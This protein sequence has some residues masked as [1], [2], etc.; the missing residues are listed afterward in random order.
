MKSQQDFYKNESDASVKQVVIISDA[1][2]YEVASELMQELA[3]HK[4]IATLDAYQAMLPTETKFCKP[5]LL[6]HRSLELQGTD[7]AV[8][9]TVLTTTEQR[10]QHL[11]RYRDG[12]Y[13]VKYDKIM[14]GTPDGKLKWIPTET[15]LDILQ[16]AYGLKAMIEKGMIYFGTKY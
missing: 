14:N 2:R 15:A 6:P 16:N 10:T 8:D 9:G 1:L 3:K 11:E 12:A 5:A 13:C 4:N 7:M